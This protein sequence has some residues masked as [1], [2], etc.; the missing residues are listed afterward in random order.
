MCRTHHI[1]QRPRTGSTWVI[2]LHTSLC[3]GGNEARETDTSP[4]WAHTWRQH[5]LSEQA[6]VL[7]VNDFTHIYFCAENGF[8]FIQNKE[9]ILNTTDMIWRVISKG[10]LGLT[11]APFPHSLPNKPLSGVRPW[12]GG[13]RCGASRPLVLTW[14]NRV[15]DDSGSSHHQCGLGTGARLTGSCHL[16]ELMMFFFSSTESMTVQKVKGLLSRLLKVPVSELLLSYESPKVSCPEKNAKSSWVSHSLTHCWAK[17]SRNRVWFW[18]E[19][20]YLCWGVC[21][22]MCFVTSVLITPTSLLEF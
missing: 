4:H 8:W 6:Q 14:V 13:P 22:H 5:P 3:R 16:R 10:H 17:S 2:R 9:E 7:K 12:S 19:T 21:G 15:R 1:P 11:S 20:V 18:I